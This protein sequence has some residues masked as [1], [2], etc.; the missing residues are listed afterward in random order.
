ML[1][2][3]VIRRSGVDQVVGLVGLGVLGRR[4]ELHRRRQLGED[5]HG[6][7]GLVMS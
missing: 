7:A 6:G 3:E 4:Y 2:C 1:R 5:P